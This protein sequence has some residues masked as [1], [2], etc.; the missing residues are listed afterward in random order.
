[1]TGRFHIPFAVNRR[2][3]LSSSRNLSIARGTIFDDLFDLAPSFLPPPFYESSSNSYVIVSHCPHGDPIKARSWERDTI[4]NWVE[5]LS[6]SLSGR[7]VGLT[8]LQIRTKLGQAEGCKF[9]KRCRQRMEC[10]QVVE[11]GWSLVTR[12][13]GTKVC[14]IKSKLKREGWGEIRVACIA[15]WAETQTGGGIFNF[16]RNYSSRNSSS[17]FAPLLFFLWCFFINRWHQEIRK[18]II[19]D[20][21]RYYTSAVSWNASPPFPLAS[22]YPGQGIV[23]TRVVAVITPVITRK[24]YLNRRP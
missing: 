12:L 10:E 6:L 24:L 2:I 8:G 15:R 14:R 18:I 1:M 13:K 7:E 9:V 5:S 3:S 4:H 19:G 23:L 20:G 11:S 17:P 22:N 16:F 21:I